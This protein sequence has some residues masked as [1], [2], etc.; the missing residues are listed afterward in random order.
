MTLR[1]HSKNQAVYEAIRDGIVSGSFA[2]GERLVIDELATKLGVS[3]SPI[4]ECLRQLEADGFVSIR[5]YAGVSVTDLHVSLIREIFEILAAMEAIS[6]RRACLLMTDEQL[7]E[8]VMLI[9]VMDKL[10]DEPDSWS[11]QNVELHMKICGYSGTVLVQSIMEN[12]LVHWDRLRRHYLPDVSARRIAQAQREHCEILAA[13][14]QRDPDHL[15]A[16]I[17]AHNR[18]ALDAYIAH[19]RAAGHDVDTLG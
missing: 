2:P 18:S 3:Q 8:I 12:V 9:Q 4:R 7:G 5:P 17:E 1:F 13:F 6:S 10:T 14:R 16:L 15:I 11:R 19:L